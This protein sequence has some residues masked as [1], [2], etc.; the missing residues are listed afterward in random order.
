MVSFR[1]GGARTAAA[2]PITSGATV[3]MPTASDANQFCQVAKIDAVPAWNRAKPS[4]PPIPETAV[5]TTAEQPQH[6]AQPV[7]TERPTEIALDQTGR[8]E[9]F[10]RVAYREH[11]GAPKISIAQEIGNDGPDHRSRRH[12]PSRTRPESDQRARGHPG[13][14]PEY[15]HA[16]RSE[17]REAHPRRQDVDAA[18]HGGEPDR[19]R[20]LVCYVSRVGFLELHLRIAHLGISAALFVYHI[21]CLAMV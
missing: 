1:V 16:V 7:E 14:G 15:G 8:E 20:P 6:V 13:R 21:V 4:V 18:D 17:E 11:D 19:C 5:A 3:T 12:S 10:T 2:S 9:R